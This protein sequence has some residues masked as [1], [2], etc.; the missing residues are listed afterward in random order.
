MAPKLIL[1]LC[2][3]IVF[4]L[5]YFLILPDYQAVKEIRA[6]IKQTKILISQEGILKERFSNLANKYQERKDDFT[7]LNEIMPEEREYLLLLVQFRNLASEQGVIQSGL[8]IGGIQAAS[9]GEKTNLGK[10]PISLNI[11]GSY[12]SIKSYLR[13]L[14]SNLRLT[15]VTN[16]SF[17]PTQREKAPTEGVSIYS[18]GIQANVYSLQ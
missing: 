8:S 16:L 17:S 3:I 7:K 9:G 18:L 11:T 6:K 15:D 13:A 14:E 10:V 4:I 2:L 12:S 5:V 1:F